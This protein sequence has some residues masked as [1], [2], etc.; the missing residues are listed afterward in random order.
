LNRLAKRLDSTNNEFNL[1]TCEVAKFAYGGDVPVVNKAGGKF[2]VQ[3]S[4]ATLPYSLHKQPGPNRIVVG[5]K[6]LNGVQV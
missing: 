4:A 5:S 1:P 3:P 2:S 6:L